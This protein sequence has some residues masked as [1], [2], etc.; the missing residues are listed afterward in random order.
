MGIPHLSS[1][2]FV[3]GNFL[4][5]PPEQSEYATSHVVVL[6]VAYDSTTSYRSGTRDGPQAI[7]SASRHMEDF[8]DELGWEPCQAGIHTLPELEVNVDGPAE[9]IDRVSEATAALAKDGKLV[10]LL[11]GEHSLSIGA[12]RG[13]QSSYPDLSV[14]YLDAHGDLR[15]RYMGSSYSHACTARRILEHCPVVHAGVR[16][17][18]QEEWKFSKEQ[19]L[20]LFRWGPN[21]D[22]HDIANAAITR[23]SPHVYVSIDLDVLDPALMPSVGTPEPGGMGWLD[24]LELLRVVASSRQ[25]VGFDIMELA[26]QEGPHACSY[27]A[28]RLTYKLIGYIVSA[29]EG[30]L[31]I[32]SP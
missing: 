9:T 28:A 27:I 12:V 24:L 10:A 16:S 15:D 25:I 23:L 4:S 7:I 26:P 2:P 19:S 13:I 32:T 6:P 11:G 8:D 1:L 3:P 20:P 22:A 29:R 18:S 31:T 30:H 5:L 21:S 14:L 17:L